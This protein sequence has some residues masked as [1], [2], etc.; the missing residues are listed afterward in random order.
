MKN[1]KFG[2]RCRR[3]Y[4]VGII[5]R[6]GVTMLLVFFGIL[7]YSFSSCRNIHQIFHGPNYR[8]LDQCCLGKKILMYFHYVGTF[9]KKQKLR[10]FRPGRR[11]KQFLRNIPRLNRFLQLCLW[12]SFWL[13]KFYEPAERTNWWTTLV[14]YLPISWS[15]IVLKLKNMK[16]FINMKIHINWWSRYSC[17]SFGERIFGIAPPRRF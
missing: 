6:F 7:I 9:V 3:K 12:K 1:K 10:N 13:W 17:S 16:N 4:F 14:T 8:C 5:W 2:E 15:V 11:S